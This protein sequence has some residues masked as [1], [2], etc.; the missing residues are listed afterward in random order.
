MRA[1]RDQGG[2]GAGDESP[3]DNAAEVAYWS[4]RVGERA[5]YPGLGVALIQERSSKD[6]CGQTCEVLVLTLN[7]GASRIWVP[8]AKLG[9]VGL[10]PLISRDEAKQIWETLR[11]LPSRKPGRGQ[12][13]I[14]QFREFQ[15]RIKTESIFGVAE[16][17][18][19]LLLIQKEKELSF[20]EHRVLDTARTLVSEELA[21]VEERALEEVLAEI[22][23]L[24]TAR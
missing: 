23:S 8:I 2:R 16:V 20:G 3:R 4:D 13:W 10:R 14:R 6:V 9:E 12:A 24:V 15:E 5:V 21:A 22:K 1:G 7:G 18:R 19:D 17:L 11:S